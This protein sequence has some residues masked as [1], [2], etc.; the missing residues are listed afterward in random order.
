GPKGS[1]DYWA[2]ALTRG[3]LATALQQTATLVASDKQLTRDGEISVDGAA[4]PVYALELAS[5]HTLILTSSG[6]RVVVLSDAGLL[7]GRLRAGGRVARG[8][9]LSADVQKRELYDTTFPVATA[10]PAAAGAAAPVHSVAARL[11]VAS[12]GYQGFFPGVEALKFDFG[13]GS[14]STSLL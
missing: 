1:L 13:G 5:D 7:H 9:L 10:A 8:R 6:D 2:L 14:W 4:V 3:T 12:F 11:D